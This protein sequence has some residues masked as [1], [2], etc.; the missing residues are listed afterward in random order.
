MT[1]FRIQ[2]LKIYR[3]FNRKKMNAEEMERK[4]QQMLENARWRDEQRVANVERYKKEDDAEKESLSK[5]RSEESTF[6]K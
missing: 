2:K 6:V 4:R 1:Y 3:C 5:E